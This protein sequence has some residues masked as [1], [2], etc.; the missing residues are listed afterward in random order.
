MTSATGKGI[1]KDDDETNLRGV[2]M[3]N[4]EHY[5]NLK[6]AT[7]AGITTTGYASSV[8]VAS[9][10][11][12]TDDSDREET[13][14]KEVPEDVWVNL[15]GDGVYSTPTDLSRLTSDSSTTAAKKAC[16]HSK[17]LPNKKVRKRAH[18]F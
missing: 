15:D 3:Q 8:M 6:D 7:S 5:C 4:F 17:N 11:T 14:G 18:L 1:R 12:N 16:K 10:V 2:E 9:S 13:S